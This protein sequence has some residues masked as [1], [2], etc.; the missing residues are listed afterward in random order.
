MY[1]VGRMMYRMA[2]D[3]PGVEAVGGRIGGDP[4]VSS[5][6]SCGLPGKGRSEGFF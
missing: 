2:R 3:N 1:L 4:L 5:V 6:V